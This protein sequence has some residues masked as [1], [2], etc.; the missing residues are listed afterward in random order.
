[1]C[2]SLGEFCI[3]S[4]LKNFQCTFSQNVE[5]FNDVV[6]AVTHTAQTPQASKPVEVDALIASCNAV[7]NRLS[8][9]LSSEN[10]KM[11]ISSCEFH[12]AT[13][14][15]SENSNHTDES[16]D[17]IDAFCHLNVADPAVVDTVSSS[18]KIP[19]SSSSLTAANGVHSE[20]QLCENDTTKINN[21]FCTKRDKMSQGN[22]DISLSQES[23][24]NFKAFQ[25]LV[26]SSKAKSQTGSS[27]KVSLAETEKVVINNHTA[28]EQ[29]RP[30]PEDVLGFLLP[31]YMCLLDNQEVVEVMSRCGAFQTI[32]TFV[33]TSLSHLLD[34]KSSGYPEVS[35]RM[36]CTIVSLLC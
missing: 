29:W 6:M 24:E 3:F 19:S 27:R 22:Y 1:M 5:Y 14:S 2:K 26:Y 7:E 28:L 8:P 17:T 35:D 10:H 34:N 13:S 25:A 21:V 4:R 23:I 30:T 20:G 36:F 32:V 9:E 12:G 31:A 15:A 18:L 11:D 33:Q 16:G